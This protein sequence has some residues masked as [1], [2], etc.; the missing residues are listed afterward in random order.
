[1]SHPNPDVVKEVAAEDEEVEPSAEAVP[2]SEAAE[3]FEGGIPDWLQEMEDETQI[4][5]VFPQLNFMSVLY[6]VF[7]CFS[8]WLNKIKLCSIDNINKM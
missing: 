4:T 2:A 3:A 1:M 5:L 7:C 6:C 8:Q